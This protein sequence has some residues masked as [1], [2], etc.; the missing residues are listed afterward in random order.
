MRPVGRN[1]GR[2]S[3]SRNL[4]LFY[5]FVQFLIHQ[6]VYCW[7]LAF[8]KVLITH[9]KEMDK[10]IVRPVKTMMGYLRRNKKNNQNWKTLILF[11]LEGLLCTSCPLNAIQL[12]LVT[13]RKIKKKNNPYTNLNH[14]IFFC[15]LCLRNK[16]YT[17]SF[18]L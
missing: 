3:D 8:L 13:Y 16:L 6:L 1:V 10:T 17:L 11:S 5:G 14:L 15:F 4:P 7:W 12:P 2:E 18:A 9:C